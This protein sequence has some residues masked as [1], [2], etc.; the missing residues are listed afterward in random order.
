MSEEIIETWRYFQVKQRILDEFIKERIPLND[1]TYNMVLQP[2]Y[3]ASIQPGQRIH[4]EQ[5]IYDP[6]IVVKII[7]TQIKSMRR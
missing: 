5:V 4:P 6:S 2:I 7:I 3:T 1:N